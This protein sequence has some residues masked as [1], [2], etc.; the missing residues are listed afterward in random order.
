M[1]ILETQEI[2][3]FRELIEKIFLNNKKIRT[4][5]FAQLPS[6]AQKNLEENQRESGS[7]S[8]GNM[9]E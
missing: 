5:P 9:I 3:N 2:L 8:Y 6:H 1:G 4:K 7:Q